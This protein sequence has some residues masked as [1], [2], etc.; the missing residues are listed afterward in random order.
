[1]DGIFLSD[2]SLFKQVEGKLKDSS[3]NDSPKFVYILSISSHVPYALNT[4]KRPPVIESSSQVKEVRAY[5]NSIFY[6]SK[7]IAAFIANIQSSDP[8]AIVVTFGDHAPILGYNLAGY[9]ESGIVK[10]DFT[11]FSGEMLKAIS[12]TPLIIINGENGTYET[13]ELSMFELPKLVLHMAG[14]KA[15]SWMDVSFD[16]QM[17]HIRPLGKATLILNSEKEAVACF[18]EQDSALCT[19]AGKWRRN[20]ELIT[21]DILV[22]HQYSLDFL[23]PF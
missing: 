10:G 16:T 13:Q 23:N 21:S 2:G 14:I 12:S 20:V 17:P 7:A 18:N 1:M 6:T 11:A 15:P 22:G 5:A 3:L 4:S 8:D 9:R 19:Q